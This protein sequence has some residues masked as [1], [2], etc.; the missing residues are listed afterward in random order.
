M[1]L[2]GYLE[3]ENYTGHTY[4]TGMYELNLG[5][6]SVVWFLR[7]VGCEKLYLPYYLCRSVCDTCRKYGIKT[8]EYRLDQELEPLLDKEI[9][10]SEYVYI[11]NYYGQITDE[12]IEKLR[13]KFHNILLYN[14]NAFFQDP[15]PGIPTVYSL[16]KFFGIP[17][18]AYFFCEQAL[19]EPKEQDL[20]GTRM[21]H[22]LGRLEHS[23]SD[24]YRDMLLTVESFSEE[25]PKRMSKLTK[26]ILKGIDYSYV[27]K[28]REEN[29]QYLHE[30]L[31]SDNIMTKRFPAGPFVYP[32]HCHDA[33]SV[34]EKLIRRKIY[35]PMNWKEVPSL[36]GEDAFEAEL[37]KNI[38]PLPCDQR[39]GLAEMKY[40]AENI[41]EIMGE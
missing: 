19:E 38:L 1:E 39:Y 40:L 36:I 13:S 4:Y 25:T 18:G 33:Q 20:S 26:N 31:K 3:L 14:T 30:R 16:R 12:K 27:R 11:V 6:T 9:T 23:A 8:E 41:E 17:D 10:E 34:R 15:I 2:G 22:I 35:I 5:R 29:Y 37:S 7:E 21:S 24:Y 28:Q 32:C